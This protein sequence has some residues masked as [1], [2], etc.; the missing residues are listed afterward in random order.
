V[1]T[2]WLI[3]DGMD[4]E[5]MLDMDRRLQPLRRQCFGALA[6]ALVACGPWLGWWTLAPLVAAA[7]L[8]GL[9]DRVVG[10]MRR[11]EYAMFAAWAGSEAIIAV[12]VALSGGPTVPTM[13]WLAIPVV[14]LAA[15]FSDRGIAAG[16]AIAM[17]L[18]VAVSFG[19]HG[20][21]VV[22]Q[23][24]LL[25]APAALLVVVTM[26]SV[27]LMRSDV[28]HR[29][30]AVLDPLTGMLNRL[31]L[32]SRADELAEQ[33]AVSGEP[34]GLIL[35]DVDR[36]KQVNDSHGHSVGDSVLR[37]TAYAIRRQL[38]AFDLAYRVGGE[39]FLLLLPGADLAEG[40][41]LARQLCQSVERQAVDGVK[42]TVSCGVA[43]SPRG[44]AFDFAAT[45][46][47]ADRA[48]YASKASGRNCVTPQLDPGDG[49]PAAGESDG[50]SSGARR[51]RTAVPSVP[52]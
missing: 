31:A 28:E 2:S 30:R 48:L 38:R 21:V 1:N 51:T 24:P 26:F 19:V 3:R 29:S 47:S 14:T 46:A 4:R 45:F 44:E 36:F 12:S 22:E 27:A 18:L 15:R 16:V 34:V 13:S 5:R 23:P 7:V 17:G 8:F 32:E 52:S 6:I 33:S 39:E 42:V 20:D 49:R 25:I 10:S 50:A 11:P 9:T 41:E 40:I 35:V 43:A 37:Q